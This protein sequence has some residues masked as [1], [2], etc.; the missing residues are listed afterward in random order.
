VDKR[1]PEMFENSDKLMVMMEEMR[2]P[3]LCLKK[4][5][6]EEQEQDDDERFAHRNQLP[7]VNHRTQ[8]CLFVPKGQDTCHKYN[9]HHIFSPDV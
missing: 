8:L 5:P 4:I 2:L 6:L 1:F 3:M 9:H 7:N